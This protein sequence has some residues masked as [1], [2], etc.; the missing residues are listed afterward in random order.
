MAHVVPGSASVFDA[1]YNTVYSH[2]NYSSMLYVI[3]L[4]RLIMYLLQIALAKPGPELLPL[5]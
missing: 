2:Y 3:S 1:H 4:V 5:D